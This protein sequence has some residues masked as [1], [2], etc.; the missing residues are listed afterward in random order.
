ML[1]LFFHLIPVRA[2]SICDAEPLVLTIQD[3]QVLPDVRDS[4][5][6]GIA[7]QIGSPSQDIVL[8]PWA[9]NL[10]QEDKSNT[11]DKANDIIAAGGV[12]DEVGFEGS[13]TG[14]K[15]L[16][17]TSLGGTDTLT[18][19]GSVTLDGL[20]IGIPRMKWD[21]GYTMLH[22]LGLGSNSTYLNTL[23][24]AGKIGSRVWSL[25]W[26]RMWVE[27]SINGSLVL[28]GYDEEKSLARITPRHSTMTTLRV[29]L[30]D[31][32]LN[33]RD[34]S[35]E[36][37]F[38]SNAALPCC[39]VPHQQLL[40]EAPLDY[41]D[42]FDEV[43]GIN[44]T[45]ISYGLHWSARLFDT[46][47]VFDGDITFYLD[48]GLEIRV[49]NNQYIVP[50]VD[51]PRNGSRVFKNNVRE[52]LMNGVASQPATL[53]RYF[54]TSAYLMV[55]HDTNTFTLWQGNP[56]KKS[57]IVRVF[58]EETTEKCSGATAVVQPSATQTT[59]EEESTAETDKAEPYSSP[60]GAVIGGAVAASIV[61]VCLI[62][63][64]VFYYI[65]RRRPVEALLT[66]V[67][68]EHKPPAYH[69]QPLQEM[70][71]SVPGPSEMQGES[72]FV[73]ELDGNM[74][75]SHQGR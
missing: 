62:G 14:I 41:V 72:N 1:W 20:P 7:A 27:N 73:Y 25:F 15:K 12:G 35:D 9:G 55:N 30:S 64:G 29:I 26:G 47:D 42:K 52:L 13:E 68:P 48:S 22:P 6:K 45:D 67:Q 38:P 28:G 32:K 53:G 37:I 69:F 46:D 59:E 31:I 75:N 3:V 71:G 5:M 51:I 56:S 74:H 21:A 40:L 8:L 57:S 61:G 54:F 4:Y 16:V 11:F 19:N 44:H 50:F 17:S 70:P 66:L 36:S 63:L 60:S 49:P 39:L 24:A 58:D 34:G 43:T 10:F 23:R 65:R 18:L 2:A 33:F